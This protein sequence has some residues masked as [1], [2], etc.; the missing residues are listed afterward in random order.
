MDVYGSTAAPIVPL[1]PRRPPHFP[2]TWFHSIAIRHG[3]QCL[4]WCHRSSDSGTELLSP[5][6]P[7]VMPCDCRPKPIVRCT[8][9]TNLISHIRIE[10]SAHSQT[11]DLNYT[12]RQEGSVI[13][14]R[15]PV[16]TEGVSSKRTSRLSSALLECG[17]LTSRCG[18]VDCLS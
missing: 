9:A 7:S 15:N 10:G 13:S 3:V 12:P 18:R 8:I 16:L 4:Y 2:R 17:P 14:W 5:S 1:N 11:K 6:M